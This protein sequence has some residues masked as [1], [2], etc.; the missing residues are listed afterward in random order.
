VP[1]GITEAGVHFA[2]PPL[3]T[4]GDSPTATA[5]EHAVPSAIGAVQTRKRTLPVSPSG[6]VNEA[7]RVGVLST[8][9][10]P[11]A[12]ERST[13]VEGNPSTRRIR[14]ALQP[15]RAPNVSSLRACQL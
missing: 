6:S 4:M 13:G 1:S 12:G 14:V 9:D 7:A 2:V 5:F 3:A 11:A 8:T 10:A 15:E